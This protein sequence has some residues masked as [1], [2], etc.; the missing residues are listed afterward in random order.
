MKGVTDALFLG[1]RTT[2]SRF[3]IKNNA[4]VT[5]MGCS[6]YSPLCAARLV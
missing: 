2:T 3:G 5:A 6:I 1:N 4:G